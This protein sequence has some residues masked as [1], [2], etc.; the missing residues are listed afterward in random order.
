MAVAAIASRVSRSA[1]LASSVPCAEAMVGA[2]AAAFAVRPR[3]GAFARMQQGRWAHVSAP[4]RSAEDE[5]GAQPKPLKEAAEEADAQFSLGDPMATKPSDPEID[6]LADRIASLSLLQVVMLTES[7]KEKLGVD[8]DMLMSMGGGG[9]GGGMMMGGGGGG[10]GGGGDAEEAAPVVE[11]TA[12]DVM[13]KGYDAKAKI[14]VIKEVRAITGLGLKEAK[15]LVES[16]PAAIKKDIKKEEAEELMA[17]LK[18][19]GA[20]IE[21]E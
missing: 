13:L 7:L 20:E 4:V 16:A 12:F 8:A 6:A 21:I 19:I 10:G 11:K 15:E 1:R 3:A 17:K 5:L 14:K 9:G 18:E 2:R